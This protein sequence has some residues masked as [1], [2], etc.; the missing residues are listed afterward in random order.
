MFIRF[1]IFIV[2]AIVLSGCSKLIV[3][4]EK[5]GG[6][7]NGIAIIKDKTQNSKIQFEIAQDDI[8]GMDNNPLLVYI[9][10]ENLTDGEVMF[11]DH[12]VSG[13]MNGVAVRPLSFKQLKN[14][15]ISVTSALGDFGI[16]VPSPNVRVENTFF[17]PAAYYPF[18]YPFYYGFGYGYG[19]YDYSF[20][21]A[22]MYAIQERER[23]G[24]R[25][26]MAH[27]LRQNSLKKNEP[28]SGFVL[29]P[30][31]LLKEGDFILHVRVGDD[32]YKLNVRLDSK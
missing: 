17:S 22:N 9:I 12:D 1:Y 20:S 28:K 5:V 18:Y 3:K 31:S 13:D 8:G 11:S 2:F 10:V 27:Y 14:S 23:R 16:E 21:R 30:Y 32:N 24:R 25:I 19:F 26:L 4:P 6:Y 7:N 29:F 15:D